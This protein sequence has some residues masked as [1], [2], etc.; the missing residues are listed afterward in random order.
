LLLHEYSKGIEQEAF[1]YA[2]ANLRL[3]K[4][5]FILLPPHTLE[6]AETELRQSLYNIFFF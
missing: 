3:A 1:T 4:L 5:I 2:M 6:Y